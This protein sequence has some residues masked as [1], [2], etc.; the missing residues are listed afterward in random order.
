MYGVVDGVYYCNIDRDEEL[1]RRIVARNNSGG[2]LQPQFSLRPVSTKYAVLPVV[3]RRPKPNVTLESYPNYSVEDN[4]NPGDTQGPWSGF[5]SNIDKESTL[6]N[7]FFALQKCEQ[8]NYVPS[9]KSD[10][11]EVKAVGRQENQPFPGLFKEESFAPF[12]PN[13]CQVGSDLWGN[14]TRVQIRMSECC[15]KKC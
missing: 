14:N 2:P 4:F 12:N 3:D 5:A 8:S 13:T 1:N 9:T 15:N 7:Q 10:M 6:R 11:Y